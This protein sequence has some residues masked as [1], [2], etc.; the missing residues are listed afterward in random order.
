MYRLIKNSNYPYMNY[1]DEDVYRYEQV[2]YILDRYYS[3]TTMSDM[4]DT[5]NSLMSSREFV[6]RYPTYNGSQ[7]G[8]VDE[9][10]DY[11]IHTMLSQGNFSMSCIVYVL[12]PE[13][14]WKTYHNFIFIDKDGLMCECVDGIVNI[15]AHALAEDFN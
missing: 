9:Q 12:K 4:Y 1:Y 14:V 2:E 15:E 10:V 7:A 5:A 11:L 3:K 13:Y 8:V 6:D